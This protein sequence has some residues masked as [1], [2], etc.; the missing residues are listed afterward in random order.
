MPS[1]PYWLLRGRIAHER[2]QDDD[3]EA[4]DGPEPE[5]DDPFSVQATRGVPDPE[6]TE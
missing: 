3:Q 5:P 2:L 6:P 4:I 1:H